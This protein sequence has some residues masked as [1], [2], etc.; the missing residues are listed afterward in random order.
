MIKE[1]IMAGWWAPPVW[2]SYTSVVNCK[3]NLFH[4]TQ[5]L[6]VAVIHVYFIL[7]YSILGFYW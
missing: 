3:A 1:A 6:N 7:R 2:R 5:Q 4:C